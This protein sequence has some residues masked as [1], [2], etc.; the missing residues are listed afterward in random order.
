M[1]EM[2]D[3]PEYDGAWGGRCPG[4]GCRARVRTW[5]KGFKVPG[6]TVTPLGIPF[7][8]VILTILL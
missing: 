7:R 4:G 5:T 2:S 8:Q 6:A 3:V 1:V